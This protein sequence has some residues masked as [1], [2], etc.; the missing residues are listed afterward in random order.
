MTNASYNLPDRTVSDL[1]V[2]EG[3]FDERFF[4]VVVKFSGKP[5][6]IDA[7]RL[8][9]VVPWFINLSIIDIQKLISS[10]ASIWATRNLHLGEAT[11]LKSALE[12]QNFLA[13][14]IPVTSEK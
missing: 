12:T 8:K 6:A 5:S 2:L 11:A 9:Q 7:A 13:E 10:G 3:F 1:T 14:I 4:R